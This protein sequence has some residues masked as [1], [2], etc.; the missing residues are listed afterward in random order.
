MANTTLSQLTSI[1][2]IDVAPTDS[3]LIYDVSA[4]TEKQITSSELKNMVGNG[5]FTFTI[6]GTSDALIITSTDEGSTPAPDIVFYRNSASPASSDAIGN[7]LFRGK[8]S[9]GTNRNYAGI[10]TSITS[11]TNAVESGSMAFHTIG[12]GTL[13]ERVR[14]TSTGSVGIGTDT[15]NSKLEVSGDGSVAIVSRASGT[16]Y[17]ALGDTGATDDG[18]VLLY[19]ASGTLQALIRGQG[20]SYLNGGN[21]GIGTASPET[22]LHLLGSGFETLQIESTSATEDPVLSL[23]NDNGSAAEWSLRLDKSDAAKF[24]IR[25]NNSQRVTIDTAG[26]VGI[27]T[28]SIDADAILQLNSTTQ[29]FLPPRMT[30]TQRNAIV[31][32]VPAGLMIYNTT[33]NKLNFYNGTAWEAVTSA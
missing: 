27:G 6:S 3:F 19:D 31:A 9:T 32:P 4:N 22:S 29:G 1:V 17:A 25:Y 26:N 12:S 30:T 10:F 8:S 24:Q 28:S 18:G 11:P 16:R 21:V 5:Q 7:I 20:D 33:T 15:P 2:G 23:T 14:I 13:S